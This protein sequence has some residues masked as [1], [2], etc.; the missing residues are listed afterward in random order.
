[1]SQLIQS[2]QLLFSGSR[3][4]GNLNKLADYRKYIGSSSD[5]KNGINPR[6]TQKS[7]R[8]IIHNKKNIFESQNVGVYF[9]SLEILTQHIVAL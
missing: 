3:I 2:I 8:K 1:L 4:P 7:F 9:E 6:K 5:I